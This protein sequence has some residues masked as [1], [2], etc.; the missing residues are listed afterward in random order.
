[1]LTA[2]KIVL[3]STLLGAAS[4]SGTPRPSSSAGPK[5]TFGKK[6]TLSPLGGGQ[7]DTPQVGFL[8]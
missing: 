1:M 4:A 2:F 8:L 6:C 3:A 5:P 7:D